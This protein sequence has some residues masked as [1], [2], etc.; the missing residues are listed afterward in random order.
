MCC[1]PGSRQRAGS[2][3]T[4]P[5][6]HKSR[7]GFCTVIG[8]DDFTRVSHHGI[9]EP[10]QLPG[11]PAR[12]THGLRGQR[13]GLG[14]HARALAV[15][16]GDGAAGQPPG[17]A[18]CRPGGLHGASP[19]SRPRRSQRAARPRRHRHRRRALGAI[20][21]HGFLCDAVVVSDDAGQFNVGQHA[22]WWVHAER[23]VHKLDAFT[24]I[25]C[26]ALDRNQ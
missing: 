1:G 22:L 6:R 7:N 20:T 24:D 15:V 8:N 19:G 25:R 23:L 14:L 21:A 10:A 18:V 5:A 13:R 17:P 4:T 9:E 12:R 16:L 3:S 2:R 11:V 26:S